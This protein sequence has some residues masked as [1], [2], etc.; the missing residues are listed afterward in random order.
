MR[1]LF[2]QISEN[3]CESSILPRALIPGLYQFKLVLNF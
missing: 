2:Q 3:N 1:K